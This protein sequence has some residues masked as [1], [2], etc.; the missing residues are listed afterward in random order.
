M[1]QNEQRRGGGKNIYRMLAILMYDIE[2]YSFKRIISTKFK[3][4]YNSN[5]IQIVFLLRFSQI[6]EYS[7]HH[8]F[9]FCNLYVMLN[10]RVESRA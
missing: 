7:L 3:S 5:W 8:S 4:K 10:K 6:H 1:P 2:V 9:Q